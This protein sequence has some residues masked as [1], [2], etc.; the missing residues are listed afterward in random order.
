VTTTVGSSDFAS[1]VVLLDE[2]A[3]TANMAGQIAIS[4]L[5]MILISPL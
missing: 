5:G 4:I 1:G 3:E 2:H